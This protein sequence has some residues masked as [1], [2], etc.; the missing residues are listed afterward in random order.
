MCSAEHPILVFTL[1]YLLPCIIFDIYC[2][3]PPKRTLTKTLAT[4]RRRKPDEMWK[5]SKEPLKQPLLKKLLGRE[6]VSQEACM[7]FLDILAF[8]L[9]V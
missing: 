4:A 9:C 3:P 7:C 6:E 1:S 8:F 5:Y 2:R